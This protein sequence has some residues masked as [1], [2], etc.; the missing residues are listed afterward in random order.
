MSRWLDISSP[1][2]AG[3]P[4]WPGTA[5]LQVQAEKTLAA[6]DRCNSSRVAMDLHM[7]THI[8]APSH[9]LPG[10]TTVDNLDLDLLAGPAWVADMATVPAV[11]AATLAATAIPAGT[12]R[13]LLKTANSQRALDAPFSSDYV[14]LTV[15]GAQWVV[16]HGI[17]L[18]GIDYLS[19]AAYDEA[20]EVHRVLLARGVVL[21]EGLTLAAVDQGP[22]ELFCFPIRFSGLE[23][24]PVRALLR[25]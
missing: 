24:A 18:V 4:H 1:L 22:Y 15:S 7:G 2:H 9:F 14:G 5:P 6:G 11:S 17:T 8:D 20:D 21:L 10:G 19:V 13:L 23:A 12:R 3:M 25:R 16:E